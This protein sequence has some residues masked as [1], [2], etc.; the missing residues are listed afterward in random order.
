MLPI[1]IE[2]WSILL[3]LHK[4]LDI[5]ATSKYHG[6]V[7]IELYEDEAKYWNFMYDWIVVKYNLWTGRRLEA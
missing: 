3:Q 6:N 7:S 5:S 4:C 1:N 2:E